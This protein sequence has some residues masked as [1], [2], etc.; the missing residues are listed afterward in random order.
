MQGSAPRQFERYRRAG[1]RWG[2]PDELKE[3]AAIRRRFGYRRLQI[4]AAAEGV[5]MNTRS[6]AGSMPRNGP[7]PPP[8]RAQAR[9][10][11]TGALALPQAANERSS[12]TLPATPWSMGG[13]SA[14]WL[15]STA[16]RA[17]AC[18]WWRI[19]R[20][21]GSAWHAN[22]IASSPCASGRFHACPTTAPS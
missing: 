16:S 10:G 17:N 18:V 20:C 12:S 2:Y 13:G 9:A 14:S 19:R 4:S 3:L 15:W 1:G 8:R 22:S 7:G 5:R 11:N 21:P 6:F